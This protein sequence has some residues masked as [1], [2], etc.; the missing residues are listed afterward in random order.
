[1][2]ACVCMYADHLYARVFLYMMC[3]HVGKRRNSM[4]IL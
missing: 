4:R 1:V 2:C 3:M